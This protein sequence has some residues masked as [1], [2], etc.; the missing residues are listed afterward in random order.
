MRTK[1]IERFTKTGDPNTQMNQDY[2]GPSDQQIRC[3]LCGSR[4]FRI[5][6]LVRSTE[7][8]DA[9]RLAFRDRS[10]DLAINY[11]ERV[12]CASCQ[13]DATGIFQKHNVI[14]YVYQ[15]RKV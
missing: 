11:V 14:G 1:A 10:I 8:Y 2:A 5:L 13:R 4:E 12:E 6:G 9:E 15:A 3:T 7:M